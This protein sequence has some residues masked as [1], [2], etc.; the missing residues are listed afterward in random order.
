M[1]FY[2]LS[3]ILLLST[4]CASLIQKKDSD[5]GSSDSKSGFF[6]LLSNKDQ[7]ENATFRVTDPVPPEIVVP[8]FDNIPPEISPTVDKWVQYF[9]GKGR[10]H[11]ERYLARSTRYEKIMKKIL[12]QNDMP[13]DLIYIALIESGFSPRAISRSAAVGYWQFIRGTGKRYGLNINT[14]IDERRDP[15]VAT[16]AAA[17]YFKELYS[18]FNSWFL[19]MASYNVGEGRIRR[20][21][22]KNKTNDFWV[23]A[24]KR[25]IPKETVN[26]VP[27]FLAARLIARDPEKYGFKDI[28][29]EPPIEFETVTLQ[30]VVDMRQMADKMNVDYAELKRLNPKYRGEVAPLE[31][32]KIVLRVPLGTT[33]IAM[34]SALESTMKDLVFIADKG[35][36]DVYK[37][38]NGD[39][40]NRIARRFKTSVGLLR[41]L[42]DF[43]RRVKL[44]PGRT[45]FI[46]LRESESLQY[47]KQQ[48][49]SRLNNK[50]SD[51]SYIENSEK[52]NAWNNNI[53][54]L[55][56]ATKVTTDLSYYIVQEGEA[57][58][59]V[60]LKN[61]M[62]MAE[63][64]EINSLEEGGVLKAGTQI[65]VKKLSPD[66]MEPV[67]DVNLS[68]IPNNNQEGI[69]ENKENKENKD[70]K[71]EV[72]QDITK[73]ESNENLT[74]SLK[75]HL[76]KSG[77]NLFKISKKYGVS[78]NAIKKANNMHRRKSSIK[79]G[80]VLII[81]GDFKN[82]N[83]NS[84][85]G[86]EGNQK[87]KMNN[88]NK[89]DQSEKVEG[90]SLLGIILYS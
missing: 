34:K 51:S 58:P 80:S 71:T 79:A 33:E 81:P 46:P 82:V 25:R 56:V 72:Q 50:S 70:T 40:L 55:N 18:E 76:V 31:N 89:T 57:L 59:E 47:E 19:S 49:L 67:M 17:D 30:Q 16:Q 27:K 5:Q 75:K 8:E 48:M 4:G 9:Q 69:A 2:F 41:E 1:K 22:R 85:D 68:N 29:Y 35:E 73:A 26:Y 62:T 39:T 84:E 65:K 28:P 90:K 7:E 43:K 44:S 88:M 74:N 45:I 21:I 86:S 3:V 6:G 32:G 63:L 23:L 83:E 64:M 12:R 24:K 60:A 38:R 36:T 14:F 52:N 53:E 87:N 66:Q 10:E 15:V 78:V 37:V 13:E 42:N 54:N 77:E 61:N 11:M 20:E